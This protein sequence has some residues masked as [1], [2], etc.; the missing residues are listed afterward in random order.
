MKLFMLAVLTLLLSLTVDGQKKKVLQNGDKSPVF[1][2]LDINGKKVS[3]KDFRGKYV[4]IDLWHTKCGPCKKQFPYLKELEE[5]MQGK[6]IVFICIAS[7]RK[8][9]MWEKFV[10]ENKLTG[11][12]LHNGGDRSYMR[13]YGFE[14]VPRFILIDKKG[15]IVECAMPRPCEPRLE[16]MLMKMID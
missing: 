7:D 9:E 15:R 10:K 4:L 5:K 11:I 12:Q 14:T 8:R 16:Q 1:K 3:L 6:N 13:A 2:F